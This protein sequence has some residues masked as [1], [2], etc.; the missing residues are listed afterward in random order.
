MQ[1]YTTQIDIKVNQSL[2]DTIDMY[3]STMERTDYDELNKVVFLSL[4]W[5]LSIPLPPLPIPSPSLISL[6]HYP[7]PS[8]SPSLSLSLALHL[9]ILVIIHTSPYHLILLSRSLPFPCPTTFPSSSLIILLPPSL[10]H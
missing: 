4:S 6:S 5:S 2:L 7:Y 9:P 8:L 1:C 10:P 3:I